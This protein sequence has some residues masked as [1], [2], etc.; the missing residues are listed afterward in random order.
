MTTEAIKSANKVLK[1]QAKIRRLLQEFYPFDD[2]QIWMLE[3]AHLATFV[4]YI[5]ISKIPLDDL[6]FVRD[7]L[8]QNK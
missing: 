2:V 5:P 1:D 6:L 4:R 7:W 8:N 3:A